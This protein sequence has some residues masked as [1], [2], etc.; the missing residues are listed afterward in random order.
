MRYMIVTYYKKAS[1]Q[2]D[3]S[4]TV[5]NRVKT[6]DIQTANVILDFKEQKVLKCRMGDVTVDPDW[7]RILSYYHQHYSTTI[8]RLLKENGYE[9]V[10]NEEQ[11]EVQPISANP[12]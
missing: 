1:G 2:T 11:Q 5:A 3:E 8:E 7:V 9:I 4:V 6:R 10:A 12:G